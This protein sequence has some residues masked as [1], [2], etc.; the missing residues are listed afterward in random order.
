MNKNIKISIILPNYNSQKYLIKTIKSILNQSFK[1]WELII[2]DDN[3][4]FE[5][6][7]IL[8]KLKNNKKI[9][10]FFLNKN[11]G[12]G[13][14]RIFGIKKSKS[15]LI[16][17][18]DSDDIWKKNKLKIQYD[19]MKKNN[20]NFSFTNYTP[21]RNNRYF[22]NTIYPPKKLNFNSFIRD[23]SIATSSMMIDKKLLSNIKLSK[24]PN[25]EDYFLK[26]QILKKI[27]FAYCIQKNLLNYR[28]KDRS[29]S[30]NKLR[31]VY[32][33]WRINRE[34]NR[35]SFFKNII[36]LLSISYNSIKKYGFK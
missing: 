18:I 31:N 21:F 7:N 2:V 30:K 17:F 11:K 34:F 26:C 9:K 27:N 14:C 28:I 5:T 20:F 23:T 16:A 12:D 15:K 8:H 3:S 33:L 36:S 25:F 35:L 13:Y 1:N 32:W 24:S 4:N 19:F 22:L 6:I 10:I 29:L